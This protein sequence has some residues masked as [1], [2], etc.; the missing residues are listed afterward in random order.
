MLKPVKMVKISVAGP[1]E[2]LATVSDILHRVNAVHIEDPTEEEYFKLGEPLEK[3]S[4][5]SRSL[6]L[7]RSYLSHLKIDPEKVIPTRKFKA[8][9]VE[10][11]IQKKLEEFQS[12]IGDRIEKLREL[13]DR[14]KAL[15]EE[16]K[17]IEPLKVL[18]IPPRLLKG[19]KNVRCFVGFL[20]ANPSEK[21]REITSDFVVELKEFKKEYVGAV[22][23]K[24]DYEE[25]VFRVLQEFGFKEI[26][27]PDVED[28]DARLKEI[29]KEKA[30]IEVEKKSLEAELEEIKKRELEFMLAMEEYLSIE[31]DK[32]E[33]PLRALTSKYAFVIVGYVP[34]RSFKKVKNEIESKTNGKVAVEKIEDKENFEPPT[35]L[36]NPKIVKDFE[37][38]TTT[39]AVPKYHEIDPTLFVS[40]FFPI[41]FGMM[42]GDVGYGLLVTLLSLYLKKLF[43]SEGMQKLLNIGVYVGIASIIFGLI[44]GEFFGPFVHVA[45]HEGVTEVSWL[46]HFL[47]GV[48]T[49]IGL[50][51]EE[52]HHMIA[53]DRIE[54]PNITL[55]LFIT[56]VLGL[57]KIMF[58]FSLGFYN[59]YKEHGLKE[60]ILEKGTWLF[61]MLAIA[62]GIFG[63]VT[64]LVNEVPPLTTVNTFFM[65]GPVFLLIWLVLFLKAEIPKMGGI[66]VVLGIEL[67]TWFGQTI[68]Y[69]RLLAV[70][71]SSVYIAYVIN[72][73]GLKMLPEKLGTVGLAI[74]VLVLILGHIVNT[75]L[76]IMD[77]GIQS[78]RLHYVEFFTKFVE[79]GGKLFK[80]FGR[81]K[82]FIVDE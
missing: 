48:L 14:V 28:F 23:V 73:M 15:E 37:T 32:S 25:E 43:R 13:N 1:K 39:F 30:T 20:N 52:F 17:I 12:E 40:I 49:S 69:A 50:T 10:K 51:A 6:V 18:G 74:G 21:I 63:F 7:L 68:S 59:V 57:A 79:G 81:I 26:P 24:K 53:F 29:E 8:S 4:T 11:E 33:L 36:S 58:G 19:Y 2:Y 70:G 60:A 31:L 55:L 72:F 76:G 66:G 35:M 3:A 27:V 67:L 62:C 22:F 34:A 65:I 75:L 47:T 42:L 5:I 45:E 64:N 38:L 71:L 82:R 46:P 78:L 77:P 41:F 54:A 16:A 56:I 80:P 9:E 61:G 44:Y